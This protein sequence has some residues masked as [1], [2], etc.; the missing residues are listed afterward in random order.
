[1]EKKTGLGKGLS[2]I[3]GE[4][5]INKDFLTDGESKKD[6]EKFLEI[7]LIPE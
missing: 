5:N 1:M 6:K 3:F 2:A 7:E 4:K